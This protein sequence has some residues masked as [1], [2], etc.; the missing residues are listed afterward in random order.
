MSLISIVVKWNG[1]EYPIE[2]LYDNDS[3]ADLKAEI[4]KKTGV[5]PARQKLLGLKYKGKAITEDI[6]LSELNLRP[7]M[8]IMMVGSLED[9]I[10]NATTVPTN[11][12]VVADDFDIEEED[13]AVERSEIFL[14]KIQKRISSYEVKIFNEPRPAAELMR[15]YLHEF[16]T[17]AYEDYDIV[18]WSATSM[19][20]INA[21]MNELGVASNPNYKIAFYLDYNGIIAALHSYGK[22][23]ST[24]TLYIT[25]NGHASLSSAVFASG[26]RKNI[27]KKKKSY[28]LKALN[29]LYKCLKG[30]AFNLNQ[31]TR[32]HRKNELKRILPKNI[33]WNFARRRARRMQAR[34]PRVT[35]SRPAWRP[36]HRTI[37][38]PVPR[39]TGR[40]ALKIYALDRTTAS[41]SS[42]AERGAANRRV[43]PPPLHLPPRPEVPGP[44]AD[45]NHRR[46]R[47]R[48]PKKSGPPGLTSRKP[49]RG[50]R[51]P[52]RNTVSTSN[53]AP[54]W[55][56]STTLDRMLGGTAGVIQITKV[57]GHQLL[58]L[59]NRGLAER[60]ISE[61]LEVEGTLLR[62][63]PFRKRAERITVG[64][65]PFFVG[66]SAIINALSP[67]GRVTSI[68]PK[69]MKAGPYVYIDGRRDVFITLHEGI[70]IERLPT[71]LD[72]NIKGEAWPAYLSSG[73]RCSRCHGQGHRRAI[74]PLLAG[75]A[76]NTRSAPPTSPAGVLPPTTP[77]PP[78]RSATQPPAPAPSNPAMEIPGASPA[79]R[80]VTPSTA[81]R[82]SP[83]VA[84]AVPMEEAPPAPPPVTPAPSLQAPDGHVPA[85]PTP[86][87]EMSIIE[88]T[89]TSSTSSTRHSTRDGLL[90][91]IERNPG[92]SFAGTDALGL[93]REEVLDLLSPRTKAQKQGPLLSPPQSDA[94]A[95]LIG[96]LLDLRSGGSSNI[97]KILRQVKAELRTTPAAVPPTFTLPAPRPAE[98][99]PPAPQEKE[100]TPTMAT[101]PPPPSAHMED[102]PALTHWQMSQIL[103]REFTKEPD[104]GPTSQTGIDHIELVDA[105]LDPIDREGFI[106]QLL[107]TQKN[108]LAQLLG[109]FLERALDLDPYLRGKISELRA[110]LPP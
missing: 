85:A 78:Q 24:K 89:S 68:A 14:A 62:A 94:L 70:T 80:A 88:E 55:S 73:I 104:L 69:Q 106:A 12:P 21:K 95:G 42:R 13:V 97:Y 48:G 11:L 56:P 76:N 10:V 54:N 34:P 57:N 61:G 8:K 108:N 45:L 83:P 81:P 58:G 93:G 92:V 44:F 110:A 96:Q 1:N 7:K 67:Y 102:N 30:P 47:C 43:H 74:C 101:P 75:L 53:T 99:T 40:T 27:A 59:T 3:V 66:D 29:P 46:D 65:L 86:D 72:I 18:I 50:R 36:V 37:A 39:E 98:S 16:L 20:W 6:Q 32:Y 60:L 51:P 41:P 63:F 71:R 91:F 82:P 105:T 35:T 22:V 2:D 84:P 4:Q 17:T 23:T 19:K 107:P 25:A 103:H 5:L 90:S 100:S 15:P 79:A 31:V 33:P 77:A 49:G 87:V 64:N 28:W 52:P 9:D 109:A 38:L 26:E